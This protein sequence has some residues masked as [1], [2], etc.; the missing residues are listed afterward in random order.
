MNFKIFTFKKYKYIVIIIFFFVFLEMMKNHILYSYIIN[1]DNIKVALC[2]M[3][4][5]ENLYAK[6]YMEYYMKLGVDH[7][8]IYDD[9]D[10]GTEK[11]KDVLDKKY[12]NK[13]F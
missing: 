1:N 4:K 7:M 8:F 10:L 13:I 3:G 6:E 9:N 11:I 5:K 12:I 2:T